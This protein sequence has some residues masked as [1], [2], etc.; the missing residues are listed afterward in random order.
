MLAA[1]SHWHEEGSKSHDRSQLHK[2][3]ECPQPLDTQVSLGCTR[4]PTAVN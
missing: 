2:A 4:G 1:M 3:A